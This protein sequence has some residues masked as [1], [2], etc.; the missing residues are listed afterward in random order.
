[1]VISGKYEKEEGCL[2]LRGLRE[3][4]RVGVWK[5]IRCGLETFNCRTNFG[6]DNGRRVKFG[7]IGCA[8]AYP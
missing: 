8:V 1:M 3:G 4:Y 2:C 5:A 7:R 6:V